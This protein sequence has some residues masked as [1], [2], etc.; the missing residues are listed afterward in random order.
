MTEDRVPVVLEGENAP[1]KLKVPPRECA[2]CGGK[3]IPHG[4]N[5][6]YCPECRKLPQAQ[7]E[8]MRED[9]KAKL[10]AGLAEDPGKV[11]TYI[12]PSRARSKAKPEKEK[13][14]DRPALPEDFEKSGKVPPD[15]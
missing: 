1:V 5:T 8:A 10:E 7:R 11:V 14:E 15:A 6:K 4:K 2:A 3:F 12:D 13:K 9:R